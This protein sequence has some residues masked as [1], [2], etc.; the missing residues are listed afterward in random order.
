[1]ASR[2]ESDPR[3]WSTFW[4][5][6][7]GKDRWRHQVRITQQRKDRTGS[8][9]KPPQWMVRTEVYIG[10]QPIYHTVNTVVPDEVGL[11]LR[12][13]AQTWSNIDEEGRPMFPPEFP[14]G[15]TQMANAVDFR[16]PAGAQ[17][18]EQD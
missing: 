6:I 2:V 1:M 12:S 11:Y 7:N 14:G 8:E 13:L 17:K 5:T 9:A 18:A 4:S 15:T 3:R 10:I 16:R